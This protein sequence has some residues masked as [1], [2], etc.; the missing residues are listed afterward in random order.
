MQRGGR[1]RRGGRDRLLR[2][3][4]AQPGV[5]R[6]AAFE[7]GEH[8]DIVQIMRIAPVRRGAVET[9]GFGMVE[10]VERLFGI[11]ARTG[12]AKQRRLVPPAIV[13]AAPAAEPLVEPAIG[14]DEA[15]PDE[16]HAPGD[17]AAGA[18]R[19]QRPGVRRIGAVAEARARVVVGEIVDR[20][21]GD[22]EVEGGRLELG[23]GAGVEAR[24]RDKI[25][26]V[27]QDIVGARLGGAEV[28]RAGALEGAAVRD[29]DVAGAGPRRR[30]GRDRVLAQFDDD[31]RRQRQRV[32]EA[33][34]RMR[35]QR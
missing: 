14:L 13:F 25:V 33:G 34:E 23:N 6:R 17:M 8:R 35:Q 9:A 19:A 31:Q 10:M 7:F 26:V 18:Q 1:R 22:Q 28:E 21:V 30:L 27:P 20:L 29:E 32:A 5:A 12:A 24:H 16:A 11:A 15:A 3:R 4:A 2:G